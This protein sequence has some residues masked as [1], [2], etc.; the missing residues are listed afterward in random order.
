MVCEVREGPIKLVEETLA[1]QVAGHGKVAPDTVVDADDM[2]ELQDK[3]RR[4]IVNAV[5]AHVFEHV[6]GLGSPTS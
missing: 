5:V 4:K 2:R 1:A 3:T 6:Q